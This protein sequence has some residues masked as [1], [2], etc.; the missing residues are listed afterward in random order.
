MN[1]YPLN[2]G[3]HDNTSLRSWYFDILE[4]NGCE[5]SYFNCQGLVS[6][7]LDEKTK[8][9]YLNFVIDAHKRGFYA[10]A[11][12]PTNLYWGLEIPESEAQHDID[13][14]PLLLND[15]GFYPSIAS[16]IWRETLKDYTTL[17]I[18]ECGFDWVTFEEPVFRVD[19]PGTNDKFYEKFKSM[20]P[21]FDYPKEKN[22]KP[23]Y[24]RLQD[25]KSALIVDFCTDIAAHAKLTGARR[26]GFVFGAFAKYAESGGEKDSK[27]CDFSR[28][29]NLPNVDFVVSDFKPAEDY[30][31]SKKEGNELVA[32]VQR[33]Y[34]EVFL[35]NA[36]KDVLLVAQDNPAL[37]KE[38]DINA[39]KRAAAACVVASP[40]GFTYAYSPSSQEADKEYID[41][42][43]QAGS[44]S[45]KLGGIR[46]LVALIT[47]CSAACHAEPGY[48]KVVYNHAFSIARHIAFESHLPS[49]LKFH[50]N[51]LSQEL[52]LHPEVK[53]LVLEEHFPMSAEQMRVLRD[54]FES[55][56]KHAIIAFGSGY[57][58]SPSVNEPGNKPCSRALPGVFELIG[59]KQEEDQP[60]VVFNEPVD[61]RDVSRVRRSAFL[62]DDTNIGV[63]KVANVRRLFGSRANVLYEADVANE[64]IPIVA[65]WRDRKTLA[66]FCGFGLS[67]VTAKS[68]EKA[69]RYALKE[70]DA[71][72][73]LLDS[74]TDGIVWNQN[75]NEYIV[76]ANVSDK[77]ASAIARTG[78][79]NLWDCKAQKLLPDK[80]PTIE[81]E[82]NSFN[83]YR[84]VGRRSKFFDILGAIH[85]RRLIDGAGKAEIH[86]LAGR[87]TILVL[88]TLPKD[89]LVDGRKCGTTYEESNGAYRVK[90]EN[91]SQGERLITIRW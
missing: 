33:Y 87:S 3:I 79:A 19:I 85:L 67:E 83:S 81:L 29:A 2:T 74:C 59:I 45:S 72:E 44:I 13:N 15:G 42:I 10:C 65:E 64:K 63:T 43:S 88:R 70:V 80:D 68:A 82:P 21:D 73:P 26:V 9:A 89:V 84:I 30:I 22:N 8:E 50:A 24:M 36:G 1:A 53:V 20:F 57:G 54:W 27:F 62:G 69:I 60:Q 90:L 86:I 41:I 18:E 48:S 47:S 78:R 77:P 55:P 35:M 7:K 23:P 11:Q 28:I 39:I 31:L 71:P 38:A 32:D 5:V 34:T 12:I 16:D 58:Y 56:G 6:S 91:C 25:A 75:D 61:L 52:E 14:K 46:S 40:G 37:Q 4:S 17:L 76:V 66:L 49:A 51:T